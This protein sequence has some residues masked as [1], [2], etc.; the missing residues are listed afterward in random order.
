MAFNVIDEDNDKFLVE[1]P[2]GSQFPI[3]KA[4]LNQDLISKITAMKQPMTSQEPVIESPTPLPEVAAQPQLPNPEPTQAPA[5]MPAIQQGPVAPQAP[6][7]VSNPNLE[8]AKN[9][10]GAPVT[11]TGDPQIDAI[12]K[13]IADQAK[14]YMDLGKIKA[15]ESKEGAKALTD[16]QDALAKEQTAHASAVK[17]LKERNDLIYKEMQDP[18][19]KLDP[20]R[21]WHKMDTGDKLLASISLVLGG[22]GAGLGH[23]SNAAL[24][25][26]N[27]TIDHD[28]DAQKNEKEQKNSLYNHNLQQLHDANAAHAQTKLDYLSAYKAK[29]DQA[30]FKSGSATAIKQAELFG[31]QMKAQAGPLIQTVLESKIKAKQLGVGQGANGQEA[32]IPVGQEP[33]K[34]LEDPKYAERRVVANDRAYM[35]R[36]KEAAKELAMSQG[37]T[38]P[39]LDQVRQLETLG[40]A[41]TIPGSEE[42]QR[43]EALRANLA[44]TIPRLK[45]INRLNTHEI[46][47]A[48]QMVADPTKFKQVLNGDARTKQFFRNVQE[49]LES[50]RKQNLIGYKGVGNIQGKQTGWK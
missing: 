36:D 4:G 23:T 34:M 11:L 30:A 50:T 26:I 12:N 40:P 46:E 28:I 8:L 32:G 20:N 13:T 14:S 16:Y 10:Q 42:N 22:I 47:L 37:L 15:Q 3:A 5:E 38:E 25:V 19:S 21:V 33:A 35:A 43:A 39:V 6:T 17:E 49:E 7:P 45:G 31:N 48:G 27:R 18:K 29:L 44:L 1:H 2:D 41:A 24:D 9:P